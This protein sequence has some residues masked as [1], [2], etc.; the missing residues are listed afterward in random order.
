MRRRAVVVR[1]S[2]AALF[3][4]LDSDHDHQLSSQRPGVRPPLE[5]QLKQRD[6]NDDGVITPGE[7]ILDPTAIAAAADP[8]KADRDLN[9][10]EGV[11]MV[12]EASTTPEQIADRLLAYYDRN[13][14]G[15]LSITPPQ[16][17]VSLP[18]PL[19]GRLDANSDGVF[20]RQELGH[21]AEHRFDLELSFLLGRASATES[22]R[23]QRVAVDE[24]LRVRKKLRD[25]YK[26]ELGDAEIDFNRDN[27]DPRQADL[28]EFRNFDRDNNKYI[29]ANEAAS[30]NIGKAAFAVM[31]A[32]G[33]GKV[34]KG[35]FSSFM[36][37]QNAAAAV[38][39]QLEVKDSGQN[40]FKLLD[41][42]GDG[43]LSQRE[44]R[45]A[46]QVLAGADKSHDGLLGGDELP[47]IIE[48]VL[49]RGIDENSE[50]KTGPSRLVVRSAA[51]ASTSGPLWFRKMDRNNDGDLSQ[52]EFIGPLETFKKLDTNGDGF[53]DR[54]EAEAVK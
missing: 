23:Q 20:D 46:A 39:L 33:D 4:L 53:I 24:G 21:F 5:R 32:D 6:F 44:Q 14:D 29:D 1:D 54:E 8:A 28:V 43:V 22:R 35:E 38:R 2:A 40:L 26:L 19:V 47:Q 18:A 31:D 48:F 37:R 25:G 27:R 11:V 41:V 49:G 17:E 9:A 50:A 12:L 15:R 45:Q 30:N 42:D 13:R 3:P 51:K 7:L 36:A 34:F 16:M 52:S 10:D